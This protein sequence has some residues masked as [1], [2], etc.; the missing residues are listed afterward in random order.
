MP[1]EPSQRHWL[2][3]LVCG[4]EVHIDYLSDCVVLKCRGCNRKLLVWRQP[5][6]G[7]AEIDGVALPPFVAERIT[8]K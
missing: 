1:D 5:P 2:G 6:G 8:T 7:A 4:V 3:C